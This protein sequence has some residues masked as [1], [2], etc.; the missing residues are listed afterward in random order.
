MR[1]TAVRLPSPEGN[2]RVEFSVLESFE[3]VTG[4]RLPVE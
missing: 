4:Q 2:M 1:E 3:L